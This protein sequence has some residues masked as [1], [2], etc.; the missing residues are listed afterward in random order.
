MA[1]EAAPDDRKLVDRGHTLG[2]AYARL[3]RHFRN[4]VHALADY[5]LISRSWA[6]RRLRQARELT[7][8]Q[9]PIPFRPSRRKL[10][11]PR[12]WRKARVQRASPQ[13]VLDFGDE[14]RLMA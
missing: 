2:A 12:P 10:P 4:D 6:Y 11:L 7:E 9:A 3:T 14:S 1:A 8:R 13:L 5:L